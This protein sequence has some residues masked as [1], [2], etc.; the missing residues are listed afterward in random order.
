M[1]GS[2]DVTDHSSAAGDAPPTLHIDERQD[3]A[4]TVQLVV[5]GEID[6]A[7]VPVLRRAVTGLLERTPA[8][9]VLDLDGVNFIDSSGLAVLLEAASTV[10]HIELRRASDAVRRVIELSGLASVLPIGR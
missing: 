6:I 2:S 7:T 10:G 3:G 1:D 4:G 5:I 8:R 9:L